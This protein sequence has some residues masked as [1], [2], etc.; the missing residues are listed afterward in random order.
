MEPLGSASQTP[1]IGSLPD[2]RQTVAAV[3]PSGLVKSLYSRPS[4]MRLMTAFQT[5]FEYEVVD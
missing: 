4:W 1:S 2:F 5:F 3:M